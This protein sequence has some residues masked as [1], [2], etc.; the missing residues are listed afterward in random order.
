MFIDRVVEIE[1]RARAC[2]YGW[3]ID[4]FLCR[5]ARRYDGPF[6][7]TTTTTAKAAIEI[8]VRQIDRSTDTRAH[9]STTPCTD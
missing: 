1:H 9:A 3:M 6:D 4:D 8:D 5:L 7:G 2:M